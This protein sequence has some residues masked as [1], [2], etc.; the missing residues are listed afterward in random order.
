M[1]IL[2]YKA[3]V[4]RCHQCQ[5]QIMLSLEQ[6]LEAVHWD[7]EYIWCFIRVKEKQI[8]KV[9]EIGWYEPKRGEPLFCFVIFSEFT[10]VHS[11]TYKTFA[12]RV[13]RQIQV[14]IYSFRKPRVCLKSVQHIYHVR[15]ENST[16]RNKRCHDSIQ[17]HLAGVTSNALTQD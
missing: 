7:S 16:T 14:E 11:Q 12:I 8:V 9:S 4:C 2:L 3:F 10:A 17:I 15:S 5:E 6:I 13:S 1:Y